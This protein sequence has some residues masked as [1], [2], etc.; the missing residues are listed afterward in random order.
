MYTDVNRL[1]EPNSD[2]GTL[3]CWLI[4]IIWPL[5]FILC[6]QAGLIAGLIVSSKDG[7][8]CQRQLSEVR[9]IKKNLPGTRIEVISLII[10]D[11][12]VIAK[13]RQD[14]YDTDSK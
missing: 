9:D 2:P 14:V 3:I 13:I 6:P 11:W 4:S 7:K 1:M 12:N 5:C 10:M 8:Q